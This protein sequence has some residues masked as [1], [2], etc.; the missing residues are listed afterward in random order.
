MTG[1]GS[2][3]LPETQYLSLAPKLWESRPFA[4][5]A[6]GTPIVVVHMLV[7]LRTLREGG[8][9]HS[10]EHNGEAEANNEINK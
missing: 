2:S 8:G 9:R 4:T 10:M 1:Q 3:S 5:L 7:G 6:V